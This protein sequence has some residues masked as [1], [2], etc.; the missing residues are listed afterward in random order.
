MRTEKVNL[1]IIDD[2]QDVREM[3]VDFAHSFGYET[4][5]FTSGF[6]AMETLYAGKD[7]KLLDSIDLVLL[8]VNMPIVDGWK[9]L[10]S[11]KVKRPELPV[12][13][14]SA[15]AGKEQTQ[16]AFDMGAEE[17]MA[18]P[19]ELSHLSKKIEGLL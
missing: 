11:L 6:S 7:T 17:L 15:F 18:K 4:S 2:D 14:I 9:V 12:I 16:R 8:D 1:C 3:L 5:V 19:L 13:L 10:Q